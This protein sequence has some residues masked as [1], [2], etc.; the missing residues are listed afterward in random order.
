MHS[1]VNRNCFMKSNPVHYEGLNAI[2]AITKCRTSALGGL[3]D[4]CDSRG[5]SKI[6]H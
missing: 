3:M 2:N 4:V 5:Y 1:P 6:S